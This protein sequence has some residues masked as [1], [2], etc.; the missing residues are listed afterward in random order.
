MTDIL[1]IDDDKV[2]RTLLAKL[3]TGKGYKVATCEDGK[4]GVALFRSNPF[5]LVITDLIMPDQEGIETIMILRSDYPDV[6]IIALSAGGAGSSDVYLDSALHLGAARVFAKPIDFDEFLTAVNDLTAAPDVA[7]SSE[8]M[9]NHK[10]ASHT[11]LSTGCNSVMPEMTISWTP[12][13]AVGVEHI[14]NQHKELFSLLSDFYTHLQKGGG[15]EV[16]GKMLENLSSYYQDHFLQEEA[17]LKDHPDL[18]LHRHQHYSFIKKLNQFER[19]YLGGGIALS[20]DIV[21]FVSGW[22]RGHLATTDKQQFHYLKNINN[23]L[24]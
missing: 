13:L 12:D 16:I 20:E 21:T 9:G 17:F 22:L 11:Q 14:D 23:S 10:S 6:K 15:R 1:V 8:D 3:L 7:E 24:V 2:F 19:E 18:I 4:K 5:A